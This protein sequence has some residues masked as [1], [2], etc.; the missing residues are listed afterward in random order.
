VTAESRHHV[1]PDLYQA[2]A[3]EDRSGNKVTGQVIVGWLVFEDIGPSRDIVQIRE[4][5]GVEL[6]LPYGTC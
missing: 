1:V 2:R 3:L 4:C 5:Y 6:V